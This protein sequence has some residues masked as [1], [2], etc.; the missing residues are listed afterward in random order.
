MIALGVVY[1]QFWVTNGNEAKKSFHI[2]LAILKATF[3][4]PHKV[5]ESGNIM[6]DCLSS[7]TLDLQTFFFKLTMLHN[8]KAYFWKEN[9]LNPFTKL[10]PKNLTF[11]ILYHKLSKF[12]KL[13]KNIVVQLEVL[14]F[15]EDE[16]TFNIINFM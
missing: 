4:M 7:Q 10:W 8:V 3:C 5:N 6:L 9:Q 15:V 14:G 13:A 11:S 12:I 1:P 2:H 16:Q